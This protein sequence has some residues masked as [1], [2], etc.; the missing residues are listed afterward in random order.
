MTAPLASINAQPGDFLFDGLE[1]PL[2]EKIQYYDFGGSTPIRT[3]DITWDTIYELASQQTVL[4]DGDNLASQEVYMYTFTTASGA[5]IKGKDEYDATKSIRRPA[6]ESDRRLL[7]Q[8]LAM[9]GPTA[10]K[11]HGE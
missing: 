6:S 11:G 8:V 5:Q 7:Q 3:V 10:V 1:I 9:K 4:N 2:E